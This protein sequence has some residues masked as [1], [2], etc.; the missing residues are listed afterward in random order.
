P[1]EERGPG[2]RRGA[3]RPLRKDGGLMSE[4]FRFARLPILLLV[5]FLVARLILGATGVP[6]ERGTWFFSMV[7]LT[8]FAAFFF[9]AFSRR[10]GG[11]NWKQAML[12]GVTI[13]FSAQVMIL[14]ATLGSYVAGADTYFNHPTAL[15]Q[16]GPVGI[17]QAFGIRLFGLVVNSILS[18]IWGLLGWTAGKLLPE[19]QA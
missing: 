14:L 2:A 19:A 5:I 12:L 16:E 18:A 13:A 4:Y 8:T 7:V 9:G 15:N 11:Y 3:E 6:Y 17:G 10:L 1:S